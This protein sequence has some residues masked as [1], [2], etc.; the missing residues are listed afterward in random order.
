M[1][2]SAAIA[3]AAAAALS[4]CGGE[5]G[6]LLVLTTSGGGEPSQR[7]VVKGDARGSCDGGEERTL[8]SD[9]VLDARE[10]E[11]E[12]E[13]AARDRRSY[14]RGAPQGARRY[15]LSTKDGIVNWSEGARDAPPAVAKGIQ[16]RQNLKRELCPGQ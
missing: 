10:V 7:L 15:T 4:G 8:P 1:R 11:R 6:E 13:D 16:L 14:T 5:P 3:L 2:R 12:L 9:V